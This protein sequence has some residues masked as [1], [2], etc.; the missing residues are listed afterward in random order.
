MKQKVAIVTGGASGIGKSTAMVLA[1]KGIK[2]VVSG[3]R[4]A[5]GQQ[6]VEGIRALGGDATFVA[7][8]VNDE[9]QIRQMI[10]FAVNKYGRS[11]PSGEQCGDR[12]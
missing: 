10:E 11:G 9:A 5:L 2:V 8:D 7:A 1:R 3:R 12:E 6:A 4:E